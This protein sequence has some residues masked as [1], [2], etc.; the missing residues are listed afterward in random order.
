MMMMTMPVY[1]VRGL[2]LTG[3]NL[4]IAERER[5]RLESWGRGVWRRGGGGREETAGDC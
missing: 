1:K 5:G 4:D 2:E 3:L